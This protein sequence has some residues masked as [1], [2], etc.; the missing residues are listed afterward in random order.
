[1]GDPASILIVDDNEVVRQGL[2]STL[3]ARGLRPT[4]AADLNQAIM[5][6]GLSRP[7]LIV[8]DH[9]LPEFDGLTLLEHVRS[10]PGLAG[11]PVLLFS[12]YVTDAVRRRAMELAAAEI[13]DKGATDWGVV[14]DR[15][16]HHLAA[17]RA[18]TGSG[19][20]G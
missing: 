10:R 16:H 6:M 2:S 8:L 3:R 15:V 9:R 5:A 4:A 19:S 12:G 7:D 20:A 1:L 17:S 13:I 14:A 11:L 18:T